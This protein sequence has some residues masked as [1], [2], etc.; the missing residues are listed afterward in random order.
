M[1]FM[2]YLQIDFMRPEAGRR[3]HQD[4]AANHHIVRSGEIDP[5]F[6][7]CVTALIPCVTALIP[8]VTASLH[9]SLRTG[10]MT[11]CSVCI[12]VGGGHHESTVGHAREPFDGLQ[13]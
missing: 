6:I 7:P 12:Y 11:A 9:E 4:A 5:F 10:S 1:H 2:L 13:P 3:R 8:Y